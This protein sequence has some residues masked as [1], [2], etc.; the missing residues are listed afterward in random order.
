[1]TTSPDTDLRPW[2]SWT[3]LTKGPNYQVKRIAILPGQ[4]L[5]YQQHFKREEYWRIVEG[6][7]TVTLDDNQVAVAAKDDIHIPLGAAHRI[8]NTGPQTLV[9]IEIAYGD[10]L[11]EDDELRLHDDYGRQ[12]EKEA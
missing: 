6:E 10:Y 5:S 3:I 11:G 2:G 4:R 8:Q 9:L 12:I 7:G 1:M